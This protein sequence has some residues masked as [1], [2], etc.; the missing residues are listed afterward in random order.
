MNWNPARRRLGALVIMAAVAGAVPVW[1]QSRPLPDSPGSWKPWKPFA[2][3]ASTRQDQAATPALVKAFEGELLALNAIL[4]RA[5]GVE[6]PVGFSIETWG[7]LAAYRVHADAPG[8]PAGSGQPLSGGLTF[9]AFPI[10]E[11]QRNGKTVREDTGETALQQ[12]LV[13]EIER[14]VVDLTNVPEWGAVD[15][16]AFLQP[17]LLGEIAGLPRYGDVLIIARDPAALWTPLSHRGALDLVI[18]ARQA[19]VENFQQ[20]AGAY[21][22]RLAVVRDPAWQATRMKEARQAAASMPNPQAFVKQIEESIRIEE[23]SL[24]K[25]LDPAA[26]GKGLVNARRALSEV[27]DWI[28]ELSPAELAAPGCYDAKGTMFR[29]RF[30]TVASATCQPIVRPNYGY[31]N[32]ALPRSAPQVLIITGIKRCFDTADKFNREANSPS[33]AGCRANRALI[34]TLN[35]DALRVWLR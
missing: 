35:K 24:V 34:E 19:D 3:I 25:E 29:A 12:F 14:G 1:A 31:F 7:S 5:P 33:P 8:Q 11:Y 10:F 26:G 17:P 20:S 27:T 2:A 22:A 23:A 15:H 32:K 28:A 30:R 16:D 13:N 21:T 18:K 9:G 4:R 6:S